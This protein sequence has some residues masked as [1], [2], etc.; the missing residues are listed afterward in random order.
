MW[1]D[2]VGILSPPFKRKLAFTSCRG[3]RAKCGTCS[4]LNSFRTRS[5]HSGSWTLYEAISVVVSWY[6]WQLLHL[7]G[8][9]GMNGNK[10]GCI[11][12]GV[13]LPTSSSTMLSALSIIEGV[14]YSV[15]VS[16]CSP[17]YAPYGHRWGRGE[18][19]KIFCVPYYCLPKALLPTYCGRC[20]WY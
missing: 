3:C 19:R 16:S 9:V 11:V 8:F 20:N 6:G 17:S 18:P 1:L 12:G 14:L 15:Q 4:S 2:T 5:C 7:Y 13:H 10:A